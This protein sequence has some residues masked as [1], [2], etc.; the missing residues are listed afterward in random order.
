MA[1]TVVKMTKQ[2]LKEIIESTVEKKLLQL[3]R[4]PDRGLVLKKALKDRLLRQRKAVA[5]GERGESLTT[6]VRRLGLN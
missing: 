5:V 1:A 3:L 2:E 6:I 4:D